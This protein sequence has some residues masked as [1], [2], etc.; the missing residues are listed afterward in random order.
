MVKMY[1]FTVK[2]TFI[3]LREILRSSVEGL[4]V[5][6]LKNKEH[7]LKVIF[8]VKKSNRNKVTISLELCAFLCTLILLGWGEVSTTMLHRLCV[9]LSDY[10]W[11]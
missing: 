7:I 11:G 9:R 1:F 4:E 6:K 3:K 2:L 5:Y 10:E 8:N